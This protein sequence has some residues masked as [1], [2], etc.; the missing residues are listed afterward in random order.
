MK[1]QVGITM[2][3]GSDIA[4]RCTIVL[5]FYAMIFKLIHDYTTDVWVAGIL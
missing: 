3:G 5:S 4:V 2:A 1:F